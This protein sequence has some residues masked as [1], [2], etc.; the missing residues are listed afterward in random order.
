MPEL[1]EVEAGRN[2]LQ[3]HCVGS[4]VTRVNVLESGNGPR[5]GLFDDIVCDRQALANDKMPH[6]MMPQ[7]NQKDFI[8]ALL[9]RKLISACRKGKQIWLELDGDGPSVLF[10]FG[11]TGSFV[12]RGVDAAKYIAFK[13]QDQNWPPKFTKMEITFDNGIQ[14]AFCDPRRLGRI[15]LRYG[16]PTKVPPISKLACDPILDGLSF[17]YMKSRVTK[18][19]TSIKAVLL[20]QEKVLCGVGNWIADEVLYQSNIHPSK[21][22]NKLTDEEIRN[23]T[24]KIKYVIQTAVEV[25]ARSEDFPKEW[26]FHRRWSKKNGEKVSPL[27]MPNG[28]HHLTYLY[29]YSY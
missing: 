19:S 22:C 2:L 1:P 24:A 12:V 17:E 14:L 18:Y 7:F 23:L 20:D 29:I 13:I 28:N 8:N 3:T 10:H 15:R 6:V 16:D 25:D 21:A 9:N 5:N 11:M 27:K 4:R 26:L